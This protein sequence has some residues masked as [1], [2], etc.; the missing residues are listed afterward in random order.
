MDKNKNAVI[1]ITAEDASPTNLPALKAEIKDYL[2]PETFNNHLTDA[3]HETAE[4]FRVLDQAST[5]IQHLESG[6]S[7]I[8]F[9][10]PYNFFLEAEKLKILPSKQ[11]HIDSYNI[12]FGYYNKV[13]WYFSWQQEDNN[14]KYRLFLVS[15][16]EE[17]VILSRSHSEIYKKVLE[18]KKPL[19]ETPLSIRLKYIK[20]LIPFID[21]IKDHNREARLAILRGEVPFPF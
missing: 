2:N 21:S 1:Q 5:I 6:L 3:L 16:N 9:H 20:Y 15:E 14:K 17:R 11:E 4:L 12:D 13:C 8:R 10:F 7:E 18:Y 19:V